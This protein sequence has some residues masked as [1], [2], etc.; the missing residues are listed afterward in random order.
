[1]FSDLITFYKDM[2]NYSNPYIE[3]VK[4]EYKNNNNNNNTNND[5]SNTED[6]CNSNKNVD[7]KGTQSF[8]NTLSHSL[9]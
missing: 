4:E 7:F 6:N 3:Q 1:M 9:A 8:I 2:K 5:N